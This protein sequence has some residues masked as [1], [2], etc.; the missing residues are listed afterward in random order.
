MSK[1]KF[2]S[3]YSG[4]LRGGHPI[5]VHDGDHGIRSRVK[6][7]FADEVDINSI[8]RRV[9]AG[10]NPPS[11]M[12]SKTPYYAD[13]S[14]LPLSFA[15]S[16]NI[17]QAAKESF[18]A[19]PL[20]FRR[21]LDHDF[22]NLDKAP[23]ELF[24]KYGLLNRPEAPESAVG[25]SGAKVKPEGQGDSDLPGKAPSGANKGTPKGSV[26]SSDSVED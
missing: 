9:K 26:K 24:E 25:R 6:S 18:L 11:W 7:E 1:V 17:V 20:D 22:R 14:N 15:E 13:V 23:K 12:S 4:S 21:E 5:I 19:L 8:M 3:A 16:F 2:R 10:Q